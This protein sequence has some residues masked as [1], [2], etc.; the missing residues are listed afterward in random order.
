MTKQW[1]RRNGWWLLAIPFLAALALVASSQRL[2]G[3]YLPWET[4]RALPATDD[5]VHYAQDF[6]VMDI[7]AHREVTV[8]LLDVAP[9]DGTPTTLAADGGQLWQVTVEFNAASD[10]VLDGCQA[11][12][13]ADGNRY[14]QSGGKVSTNPDDPYS[15]G[16]ALLRC[17]P[18]DTPGPNY[19]PYGTELEMPETPRP[20]TWSTQITFA[21]PEGAQP[22]EFQIWWDTPEYASFPID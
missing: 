10:Q 4:S 20:T 21:L 1:W 5:V 17:D 8:R 14:G 6:R 12:L 19:A 15:P 7:T 16:L 18:V 2:V 11:A 3:L 9:I 13:V 22:D